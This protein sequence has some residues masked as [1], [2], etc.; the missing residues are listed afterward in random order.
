[1]PDY[2]AVGINEHL[3]VLAAFGFSFSDDDEVT[4]WSTLEE[5]IKRPLFRLKFNS[6]LEGE[7]FIDD[8]FLAKNL[9]CGELEMKVDESHNY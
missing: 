9:T 1:M 4:G 3:Q 6:R 5:A 2:N 8:S 7:L